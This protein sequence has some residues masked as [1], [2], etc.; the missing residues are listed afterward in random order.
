MT[1]ACLLENTL[2]CYLDLVKKEND[3]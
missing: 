3:W 1:I 2:K